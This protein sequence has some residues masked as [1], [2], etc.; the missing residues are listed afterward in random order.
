MTAYTN[1]L[2]QDGIVDRVLNLLDR[3]SV[4]GELDSLAK[5]R[6]VGGVDHRRQLVDLIEELRLSLADCLFLW[7]VQTPFAKDETLLILHHLKKVVILGEQK[8]VSQPAATSTTGDA[9][10]QSSTASAAGDSSQEQAS[11]MGTVAAMTTVDIVTVSLYLTVVACFNV[12]EELASD[13]DNS[14]RSSYPLLTDPSFLPAVHA[15]IAN[16]SWYRGHT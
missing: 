5:A 12:G 8:P 2:L 11:G 6:A 14:H 10:G 1:Q 7:A 3:I 15:E 4:S 9:G 16:V 13:S